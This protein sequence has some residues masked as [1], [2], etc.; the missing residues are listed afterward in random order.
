MLVFMA[1]GSVLGLNV[2]MTMGIVKE[3]WTL[4]SAILG[5][6]HYCLILNGAEEV[7]SRR[8]EVLCSHYR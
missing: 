5:T 4:N 6:K 8:K 3:L 1:E 2:V 7:T